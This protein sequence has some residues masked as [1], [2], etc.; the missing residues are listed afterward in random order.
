MRDFRCVV[1]L[2]MSGFKR[3]FFHISKITSCN[4]TLH[5]LSAIC[6]VQWRPSRFFTWPQL[7][8]A[9][10]HQPTLEK[11]VSGCCLP[12]RNHQPD[13]LASALKLTSACA[14]TAATSLP[15]HHRGKP[16]L[17]VN[18]THGYLLAAFKLQLAIIST[19]AVPARPAQKKEHGVLAQMASV[20]PGT[21]KQSNLNAQCRDA[22]LSA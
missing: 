11:S 10:N 8:I 21:L 22:V 17:Q 2:P 16:P 3:V 12:R 18:I 19:L 13:P 4:G 9:F 15:F 20:L 6:S 14:F 7:R 5:G 1:H